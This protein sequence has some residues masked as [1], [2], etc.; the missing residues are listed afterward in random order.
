L[1]IKYRAQKKIDR[2]MYVFFFSPRH[3]IH[4]RSIPTCQPI[5]YY[6]MPQVSRSL[7]ES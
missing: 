2:H 5:S 6:L 7:F 1:L 4:L 3:L